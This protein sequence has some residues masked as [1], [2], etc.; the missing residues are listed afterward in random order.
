M[1]IDGYV[2]EQMKKAML[3]SEQEQVKI[4]DAYYNKGVTDGYNQ[5]LE[6]FKNN[7]LKGIKED[8][9][10]ASMQIK[11]ANWEEYIK[12]FSK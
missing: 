3:N 10:F 4:Y 2:A 12:A 6:D 8:K 5:A 7:I 1:L 11:D 9:D